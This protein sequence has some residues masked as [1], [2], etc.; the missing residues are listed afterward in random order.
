MSG[1]FCPSKSTVYISNLPFSL[2]NNDLHKILEKYGRVVK[3]TLVKDKVTHK[4]KGVAFVLFLD[5]E[6][7]YKCVR[8]LN[9]QQL[10]GRMLKCSIAK[11]NGRAT[12]FIR[13]KFY[14]DKSRCYECGEEG[15]LS[16]NCPK[17]ILGD[18]IVE[19]KEKKKRKFH[20]EE[21]YPESEQ[22]SEEE[23]GEDPGLESLSA[24][25]RYQQ[26]KIEEEEYRI[27]V[28]TGEYENK[29]EE[30]SLKKKKFK[31]SDYFSDEE[32]VED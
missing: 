13:R 20:N 14:K 30:S 3:V 21:E 5:K 15:H 25:I 4:S 6:G 26:E 10:F 18:R 8:S 23:Q 27:K 7:A 22:E 9:Q 2:T 16:Y 17:N 1:G 32:E 28:A 12:E 24:A 11:D 31:K 29:N 19:K